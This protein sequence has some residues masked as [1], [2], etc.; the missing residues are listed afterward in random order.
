MS[1]V[2][3]LLSH[4][5]CLTY[6]VSHL[7]SHASCLMFPVSCLLSHVSCSRLLSHVSCHTSLVSLP[8]LTSTVSH[9]L[10]I[11]PLLSHVSCLTSHASCLQTH[12]S[13][14]IAQHC[15][16][17]CQF[18]SNKNKLYV[19]QYQQYYSI[20]MSVSNNHLLNFRFFVFKIIII[21]NSPIDEI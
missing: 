3:H 5:S 19:P 17:L 8:H 15:G 10:S 9:L 20:S 14:L 12:V 13:C 1:P 21:F 4:V 2:S 6:P 18:V 16:Q 7:L 11:L